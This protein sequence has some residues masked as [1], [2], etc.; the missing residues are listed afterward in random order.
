MI[1]PMTKYTFLIF[2]ADYTDFLQNLRQLGVLHVAEKR[3]DEKQVQLENQFNLVKRYEQTIRFLYRRNQEKEENPGL[4]N[5]PLEV[6]E[7]IE[8]IQ[9][10][11]GNI[12]QEIASLRKDIN[13]LKPWGNYQQEDFEKLEKEG[14]KLHLYSCPANKFED[15]WLENYSIETINYLK[16]ILYFVVIAK[17]GEE[18]EID[19]EPE[20]VAEHSLAS[21]QKNLD[22]LHKRFMEINE[23]YDDIARKAIPFLEQGKEEVISEIEYQSTLINTEDE[24]EGTLKMLEGWVPV[25]REEKLVHFLDQSDFYYISGIPGKDEKPPIL[26]EN[27]K[28]T[29][30]AEPVGKL[31]D[32][33]NYKELDLTPFF[34]PFFM[35]FFGF[36]LGDAGYGLIFVI[37]AAI[38]KRKV[39]KEM[40]P[41]LSLA[42]FL[43]L[44]TVIFGAVSGTF[45]GINLIDTGYTIT[46]HTLA[47]LG[48]VNIPDAII[49]K[50]ESLQGAHYKS[51]SDF[52]EA[53]RKIIGEQNLMSHRIEILKYT[54]A[55][56]SLLELTRHLMQDPLNMFYLSIIIG[57]VQIIFGRVIRVFN[58]I[59]HR[60]FKYSLSSIGWSM[61]LIILVTFLGGNQLNLLSMEQLKPLFYTFLFISG[62]LIVLFNNPDSRIFLRPLNAIWEAYSVVTGIFQD[63]LSYIRLFALGISSAV[64][65]FVFNDLAL[66]LLGVPYIGWLIFIILLLFGHSINF[67]MAS[68]GAFIHPVR[69]TFVEFYKN[70]G[71]EGGGKA[72]KP[73]SN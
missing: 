4:F 10:E 72:Y 2:H 59:K 15:V 18:I 20:A 40:K 7:R 60:G 5:S 58:I 30:L 13:K 24:A 17:T 49:D 12:E 47:M 64:L 28:F 1:T 25:S 68:L 32:L 38:L 22:E 62:G 14:Y 39:K 48:D 69:L 27:K 56:Y 23:I 21:L 57:G 36:C 8:S 51:R 44:A 9:E 31:F 43:G 54:R 3:M 45:F 42:Q 19:A 35:L 67:F 50:L 66:Q 55:D 26:L 37:I 71:F 16:G 34:A 29:K 65:G 73:F 52:L 63:L 70:A 53:V 33:P 6:L 41:I 46:Q 11:E 61:F